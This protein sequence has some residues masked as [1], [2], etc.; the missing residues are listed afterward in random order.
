MLKT[1]Q[2]DL[3]MTGSLSFYVMNLEGNPANGLSRVNRIFFFFG[4]H[5]TELHV[6]MSNQII[7]MT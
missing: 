5:I 3:K 1:K 2:E 7:A 6:N 4:Y